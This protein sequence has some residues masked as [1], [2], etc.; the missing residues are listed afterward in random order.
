MKVLRWMLFSLLMIGGLRVVQP[1]DTIT[2]SFVQRAAELSATADDESSAAFLR[3]ALVRQPWNSALYLRLAE[4]LAAQ[5]DEAGAEQAWQ[6]AL[7]RGADPASVAAQ[8]AA[9]AERLQQTEAAIH[10]WEQAIAARPGDQDAVQRLI[11]AYVRAQRWDAARAAAEQ[12][13]ARW[14]SSATAHL[15]LAQLLALDD[16]IKARDHLRQAQAD[17]AR[18]YLTALDQPDAALRLQLLGRAYLSDNEA[19]L[20]QRAFQAASAANPAYAEACAYSGFMADQLGGDGRMWLDRAVELDPDLIVARYFRA[21]HWRQRGDLDRAE[22]DLL[23]AAALDQANA[24]IAVE[25]GRVYT[26][27]SHFV[28]A[29][30]WLSKARD[31]QPREAAVWTALVE[32]YVGRAYGPTDQMLATAQQL[33]VLT[34][35]DAEAHVWLGRAY[36]LSGDRGGAERELTT[37]ARLNPRSAAAHF[38]LGRLFGRGTE[39]GRIAYERAQTFDP[40]GPIGLAAKRALELP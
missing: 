6:Q 2:A 9:Y 23:H 4:T 31:L 30:K 38:Y 15:R 7:A 19:H 34:P 17:Q 32:L 36:L 27:R 29:E 24:L 39:A 18:P 8:R 26:Q 10:W 28:E 20:A 11:A 13:A 14:P 33:V 25:L 22:S 3:L 35:D 16:P 1:A 12:W 21:R 37:A 5:H 40:G